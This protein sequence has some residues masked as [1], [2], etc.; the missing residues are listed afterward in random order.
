MSAPEKAARSEKNV[1]QPLVLC[2]DTLALPTMKYVEGGDFDQLDH[3][4]PTGRSGLGV[5]GWKL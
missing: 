1:N 4:G 5:G 2:P 3:T